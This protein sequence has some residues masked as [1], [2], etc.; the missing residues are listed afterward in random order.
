MTTPSIAAPAM[1]T[2][3]H[4]R[5]QPSRRAVAAESVCADAGLTLIATWFL[6]AAKAFAARARSRPSSES[7]AVGS[8]R[9]SSSTL[10]MRASI[11]SVLRG[12]VG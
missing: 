5:I 7:A 4:L 8:S 11:A 10:Q 9:S 12:A 6:A 1:A 3:G 2:V